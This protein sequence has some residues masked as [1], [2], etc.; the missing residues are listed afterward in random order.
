MFP[1]KDRQHHLYLRV[2]SHSIRK[3]EVLHCVF[4]AGEKNYIVFMHRVKVTGVTQMSEV[5]QVSCSHGLYLTFICMFWA[6]FD[7][8]FHSLFIQEVNVASCQI[9]ES[10]ISE[11]KTEFFIWK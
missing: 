5:N 8:N 3:H 6:A 11:L 1:E 10:I 2:L 7:I 9:P 4:E